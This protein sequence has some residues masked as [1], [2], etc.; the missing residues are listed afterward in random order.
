[1]AAQLTLSKET[2]IPIGAVIIVLSSA[3]SYGIMYQKVKTYGV[4]L[5]QNRIESNQ[6]FDELSRDV[7][8]LSAKI[9]QLI[10]AQSLSYEARGDSNR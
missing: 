10:G 6:R 5:E 3:F 8:L 9:N 4:V 2:L 1:M 7:A